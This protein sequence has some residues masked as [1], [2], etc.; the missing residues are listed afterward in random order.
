MGREL[1]LA[2]LSRGASVAAVDI[3]ASALE[4][5]AALA[6]VNRANRPPTP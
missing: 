1:V 2:L 3:N 4:E 6:G 5:T